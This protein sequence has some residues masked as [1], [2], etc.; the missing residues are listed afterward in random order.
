M[1]L[2]PSPWSIDV[3][4]S[5]D[6]CPSLADTLINAGNVVQTLL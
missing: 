2:S 3:A 6:I 4:S 1:S 5:I